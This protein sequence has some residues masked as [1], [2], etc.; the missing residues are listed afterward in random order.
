M[1]QYRLYCLGGDGKLSKITKAE[2]ID[3]SDDAEAIAI[4]TEM[5]HLVSCELWDRG[6]RVA[7]IPP[8]KA[9]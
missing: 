5:K 1:T 7:A 3:A 6:R 2:E 8:H 4:S 9:S